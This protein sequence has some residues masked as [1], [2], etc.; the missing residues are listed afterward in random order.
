M[1]DSLAIWLSSLSALA[2]I[3][4]QSRLVVNKKVY[5]SFSWNFFQEAGLRF[6]C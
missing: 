2:E 4:G 1:A 5:F 3:T 6:R